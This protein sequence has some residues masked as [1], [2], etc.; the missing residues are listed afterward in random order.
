MVDSK[1]KKQTF[2]LREKPI[3][4][5]RSKKSHIVINDELTS[6][7]HMMI[8]LDGECVFVE[9]LKSK[10]GIFLNGIKVFKQRMYIEDNVKMGDTLLYFEDK[11]MDEASIAV[12]TSEN[13]TRAVSNELTLE[14]ESHNDKVQRINTNSSNNAK[15]SHTSNKDFV[16]NSKL[17]AGVADN[18]EKLNGPSGTKLTILEYGA[19]AIDLIISLL[20]FFLPFIGMKKVLPET[21]EKIM[22][23]VTKPTLLFEGEALYITGISLFLCLVIFKLIR[24][25]KKGSIGEIILGLD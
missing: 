6:S 20:F 23:P 9:D 15:A 1:R 2:P 12:L 16:K 7:Q 17:Y 14:I 24:S 25:R 22:K 13:E 11:K 21:Y 3:I 4:I 10:N 18:A 5:G 19:T 8:Y